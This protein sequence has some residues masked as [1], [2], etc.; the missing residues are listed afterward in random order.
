MW[1]NKLELKVVE[2]LNKIKEIMIDLIRKKTSTKNGK[3]WNRIKS[4][5]QIESNQLKNLERVQ[6]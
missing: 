1:S 3:R 6:C 2:R 4:Y 5:R